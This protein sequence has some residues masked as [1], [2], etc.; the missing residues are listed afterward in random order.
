[1]ILRNE[2]LNKSNFIRDQLEH[3]LRSI[4][5]AQ[6]LIVSERIWYEGKDLKK[7]EREKGVKKRSGIL[8]DALANPDFIIQSA[9]EKFTVV[10][11][12]PLYIRFL[13]MRRKADLRVYNRQIWGILYNNALINIRFRYGKEISDKIGDAL[14]EAFASIESS[15]K[16]DSTGINGSAY[17]KAKGR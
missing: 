13:D 1:M 8:E 12:Y 10:A 4:Y 5:K 15:S 9:G 6:Q 14:R 3:D 2:N 16:K 11:N 7:V 17:E